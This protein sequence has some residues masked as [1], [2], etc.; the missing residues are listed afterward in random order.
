MLHFYEN[1]MI[2]LFFSKMCYFCY[3]LYYLSEERIF[4]CHIKRATIRGLWIFL[5]DNGEERA[6][7]LFRQKGFAGISDIIV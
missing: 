3:S 1:V 6:A 5:K 4:M 2:N 7:A